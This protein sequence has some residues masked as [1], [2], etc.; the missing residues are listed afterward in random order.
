MFL[1]T[2]SRYLV[3]FASKLKMGDVIYFYDLLT[4]TVIKKAELPHIQRKSCP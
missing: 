2:D 3:Y 1:T 4:D